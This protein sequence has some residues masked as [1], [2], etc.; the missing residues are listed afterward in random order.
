MSFHQT[1]EKR[2]NRIAQGWRT[3]LRRSRRSRDECH[4][5]APLTRLT[6]QNLCSSEFVPPFGDTHRQ[7]NS[8]RPFHNRAS[9]ILVYLKTEYSI[10]GFRR[11]TCYL[12]RTGMPVHASSCLS[13]RDHLTTIILHSPGCCESS[14]DAN[15]SCTPCWNYGIISKFARKSR[16]W[17]PSSS[18]C[19]S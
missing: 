10:R 17:P 8:S 7:Y 1:Q 13:S 9:G 5:V 19:L 6:W 12:S 15:A 3:R 14:V 4:V 11:V 2:L 18:C 16:R